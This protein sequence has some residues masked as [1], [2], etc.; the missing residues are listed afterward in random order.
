MRIGYSTIV[1]NYTRN[2]N[3]NL[4]NLTLSADRVS[5]RR[6]FSSM[7]EDTSSGVRA[8]QL[9]RALENTES[10]LNTSK[11]MLSQYQAAES[12]M[13]KVV[14]LGQD[15][16]V[17][18]TNVLNGTNGPDEH[19]IFAKE[20]EALQ[21]QILNC[22]NG[23]FA[24][25]FQFGG[26]NT[27]SRPFTVDGNG[28]LCYNGVSV[29]DMADANGNVKAE[30]QYLFE[31]AAYVDIGLGLRSGDNGEMV[32]TS[33]FKSTLN[34]L[35]FLGIGEN[36]IYQVCN[37]MIAALRS[38]S[39][40]NNEQTAALLDK[41]T[42]AYKNVTLRISEMGSDYDYLEYSVDRLE[43]DRLNLIERQ[44]EL[45]FIDSAEAIMLFKMQEYI[46]NA[47]LQMGQRVL[48]PNLFNF[49]N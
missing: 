24:D 41:M 42:D 35:E 33:A 31:D 14:E 1:R 18:Y 4:S 32:E 11:T 23:Q 3:G 44:D 26:T 46:Y 16:A 20:I 34:G 22:A 5:N 30:Y 43:D 37:Q 39:F 29:A 12:Q 45:E 21:K 27:T 28:N 36:N 19:E 9:R 47:A 38:G 49:I 25:R 15:I 6:K 7:A 40:T 8:L 17:R 13:M 2:L 10:Y 48:Q